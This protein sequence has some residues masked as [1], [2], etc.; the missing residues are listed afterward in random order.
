M[1]QQALILGTCFMMA[2][3]VAEMEAMCFCKT[4]VLRQHTAYQNILEDR[5][6]HGH[7]CEDL[8]SHKMWWKFTIVLVEHQAD[9]CYFLAA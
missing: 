9:P 6:L 5:T 8:N 1:K 3:C 2:S 4:L 7:C